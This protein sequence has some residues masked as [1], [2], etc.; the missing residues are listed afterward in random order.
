MISIGY[1]AARRNHRV[2]DIQRNTPRINHLVPSV[3]FTVTRENS[4]RKKGARLDALAGL[5]GGMMVT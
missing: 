1:D 4:G 3:A 2:T 5:L